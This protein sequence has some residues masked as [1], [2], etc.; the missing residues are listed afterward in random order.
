MGEIIKGA[1]LIAAFLLV[2][3]YGTNGSFHR[4]GWVSWLFILGPPSAFIIWGCKE[5]SSLNNQSSQSE[6]LFKMLRFSV[7]RKQPNARVKS[8]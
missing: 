3:A 4:F 2:V 5:I 1:L 6:R 8:R 7:S